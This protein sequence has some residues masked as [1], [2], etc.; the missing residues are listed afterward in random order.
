MGSFFYD[1]SNRFMDFLLNVIK[2]FLTNT[3][4]LNSRRAGLTLR[5]SLHFAFQCR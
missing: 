1:I 5:S 3:N 2:I 4:I